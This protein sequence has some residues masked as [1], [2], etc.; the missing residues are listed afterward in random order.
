MYD[1]QYLLDGKLEHPLSKIGVKAYNLRSYKNQ[2]PEYIIISTDFYIGWRVDRENFFKNNNLVI[3]QLAIHFQR[4]DCQIILRSSSIDEEISDRGRYYSERCKPNVEEIRSVIIKI[5][6]DFNNQKEDQDS[7]IAI[8][9][10]V[11]KAP[12]IFGHLSNERRVNVSKLKWLLEEQ[13]INTSLNKSTEIEVK[14]I[15]EAFNY[16]LVNCYNYNSLLK[17]IEDLSAYF[18]GLE[19]RY[20][21]EWLWDGQCFWVLQ[22]DIESEYNSKGIKPGSEW[23][24]NSKAIKKPIDNLKIF[25]TIGTTVN[26]WHKIECLK[27]FIECGLPSWTIYILENETIIE[28]LQ[29]GVI[30]TFLRSDLKKIL[31]TPIVIRTDTIREDILLPRTE[32]IYS[33]DDALSFLKNK[34]DVFIEKGLQPNEFCFLIH[35]FIVSTACAL[36]YTKPNIDITRIDSTWGIVEGLYYHSHDSFEVNKNIHKYIKKIRRKDRYIDVN[37]D[38]KWYSKE[39]GQDYDWKVSLTDKQIALISEY[40]HLV[41]KKLKKDVNLMLFINNKFNYPEVLPWFYTTN[42]IPDN[43]ANRTNFILSTK[44]ILI[45]NK[46][47]FE[48]VKKETNKSDKVTL[49]IDL[50]IELCRDKVIEEIADFAKRN[51]YTVDIK[52]SVLSHPYYVFHSKGVNVRCIDPL[53]SDYGIKEYYKL[54]RDKIPVLIQNNNEEVVVKKVAAKELLSLLKSKMVEEAYELY[55]SKTDENTIEEMADVL[56]VIHGVCKA[57]GM[58][59]DDLEKIAKDKREKRGGFEDGVVLVATKER[60]AIRIAKQQ[61]SLFPTDQEIDVRLSPK[62]QFFHKGD[63]DNF[64]SLTEVD[65][66]YLPYVTANTAKANEFRYLLKEDQYNAISIKY[67]VKNIIVSLEYID[68]D[69]NDPLQLE[70]FKG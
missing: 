45:K 39:A 36:S 68:T 13:A 57:F 9:V 29:K 18:S 35:R 10:Q 16:S 34:V 6:S 62:L 27:T 67:G 65:K 28:E 15:S 49:L 60:S 52:G 42:E 20:H 11:Y 48:K 53:E 17:S 66:V 1:T 69:A 46:D 47:D 55:W 63:I 23:R 5:Y 32:T 8:L 58:S 24:V 56:E 22:I 19:G 26:N 14:N 70:L 51:S 61:D 37:S 3:S 44:S 21:F 7:A 40:S 12:K 31:T 41:A 4:L 54:V 2:T 59:I 50:N 43:T 30:N 64:K 33:I 38:G 25:E